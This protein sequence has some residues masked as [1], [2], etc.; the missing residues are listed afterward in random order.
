ML[1]GLVMAAVGLARA[2]RPAKATG[3]WRAAWWGLLGLL[4]SGFVIGAKGWSFELLNAQFGE[5][6]LNQFG[7]GMGAFMALLSLVMI[8]AF[9]YCAARLL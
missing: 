4:A 1:I 9:G 8:T 3:F 5:L 6:A 2:R 7:I